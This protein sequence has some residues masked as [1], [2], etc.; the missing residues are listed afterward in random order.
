MNKCN[1]HKD[2]EIFTL[3]C[4]IEFLNTY[5]DKNENIRIEDFLDCTNSVLFYWVRKNIVGIEKS[6]QVKQLYN[7]FFAL[8]KVYMD[9]WQALNDD[10]EKHNLAKEVIY[11][12]EI[13]RYLDSKKI[14]MSKDKI[15]YDEN[16]VHWSKIKEINSVINHLKGPYLLLKAQIK[17]DDYGIFINPLIRELILDEQEVVYP[18]IETTILYIEKFPLKEEE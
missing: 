11:K 3:K 6:N 16:F 10:S 18:T 9:N 2:G 4:A 15:R 12:G 8:I 1:R 17:D 13:Y 14:T 7:N 5:L